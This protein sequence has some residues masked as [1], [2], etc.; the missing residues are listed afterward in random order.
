MSVEKLDIDTN[1]SPLVSES[2]RIDLE[3]FEGPLDLLLYLI[4]RDEIDISEIQVAR[5]ADQYLAYLRG[6]EALNL[7]IASEYLVMAATLMNIKSKSLLPVRGGEED[8]EA[9]DPEKQLMRQLILYKAFKDVAKS[10]RESEDLWRDVFTPGGERERWTSNSSAVIDFPGE[11]GI[12]DLLEA[13]NRLL[14]KQKDP[15]VQGYTKDP[16][17]IVDCVEILGQVFSSCKKCTFTKLVGPEPGRNKLISLFVTVLEL[18]RRGWIKLEQH[19]PFSELLLTRTGR[20][21]QDA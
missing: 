19:A 1:S 2:C 4:R 6:A 16:Y 11:S 21:P 13:F 5:V 18:V 20:W 3:A 10:L 15:P 17:P 8:G 14:Q 12:F 9:E 7:D